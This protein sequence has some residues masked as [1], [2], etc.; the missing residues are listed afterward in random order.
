MRLSQCATSVESLDPQLQT[1]LMRIRSASVERPLVQP[2][3][4]TDID[5]EIRPLCVSVEQ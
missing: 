3:R 2:H 5:G 4:Q 1:S